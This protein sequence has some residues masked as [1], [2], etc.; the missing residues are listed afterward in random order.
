MTAKYVR[1]ANKGRNELIFEVGDLVWVHLRK[2]RFPNHRKTKLD[3][4]AD[5][6]FEVLERLNNNAY[7]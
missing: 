5:G 3:A 4:R 2:N 7:P 1:Q 6:P